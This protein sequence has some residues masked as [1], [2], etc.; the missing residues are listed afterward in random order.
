LKTGRN[1]KIINHKSKMPLPV[2]RP[3]CPQGDLLLNWQTRMVLSGMQAVGRDLALQQRTKISGP[4]PCIFCPGSDFL[5]RMV[6]TLKDIRGK[7]ANILLVKRTI[8]DKHNIVL[9]YQGPERVSENGC[10]DEEKKR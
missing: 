2:L 3:A 10:V 8:I 5:C 6:L 4:L 9:K 1:P 7:I